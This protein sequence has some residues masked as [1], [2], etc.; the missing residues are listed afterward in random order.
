LVTSVRGT[1]VAPITAANSA[2]GVNAF[3]NAA[4]GVRATFLAAGFAVA[5][6]LTATF[7]TAAVF[8]ATFLTATFFTAVFFCGWFSGGHMDSP[9]GTDKFAYWAQHNAYKSERQRIYIDRR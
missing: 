8:A 3:I 6:F 4:L 1:G 2:L 9:R 5:V 7:L